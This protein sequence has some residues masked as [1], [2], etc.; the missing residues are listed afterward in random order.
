V[1]RFIIEA[2]DNDSPIQDV[3]LKSS[4]AAPTAPSANDACWISITNPVLS[5]TST[6]RPNGLRIAFDYRYGFAKSFTYRVH[7]WV[8]DAAGRSSVNA[9]T[10][11]LQDYVP[12]RY[13]PGTPPTVTNVFAMS[14]DTPAWP[15]VPTDLEATQNV[16]VFIKWKASFPNN[17][18][19]SVGRVSLF[20]TEDDLSYTLIKADLGNVA[21]GGCSLSLPDANGV[22]D[23]SDSFSGCFVWDSASAISPQAWANKP[24]GYYTV[25]VIA[26]DDRG[27]TTARGTVPPL[28]AL[29]GGTSGLQFLAGNTDPGIGGNALSTVFNTSAGENTC[30]SGLFATSSRGV[31]YFIDR[32][33]GLVRVDPNTGN[34]ELL[35]RVGATSTGDGGNANLATTVAPTRV[36]LDTSDRIYLVEFRRLRRIDVDAS[37]APTTIATILGGGTIRTAP[38]LTSGIA[39][40]SVQWDCLDCPITVLPSGDIITYINPGSTPQ[41]DF[42]ILRLHQ[43]PPAPLE[44]IPVTGAGF[45]AGAPPGVAVPNSLEACHMEPLGVEFDPNTSDLTGMFFRAGAYSGENTSTC[46]GVGYGIVEL[47]ANGAA[48]PAV[49]SYA[50]GSDATSPC[51]VQNGADGRLYWW[52]PD[53]VASLYRY[54]R[55]AAWTKLIG[56][57]SGSFDYS[58]CPDGTP[59]LNCRLNIKSFYVDALGVPYLSS[60]G[61]LR[62]RDD[63]GALV[64]IY[65]EKE[66]LGDSTGANPDTP[67]LSARIARLDQA[68]LW[69]DG[70]GDRL[71]L[72]DIGNMRLREAVVGG[73]ISTLAGTGEPESVAANPSVA[74]AQPVT[75]S[76][77]LPIGLDTRNGDVF[78]TYDRRKQGITRLTRSTGQWERVVGCGTANCGSAPVWSAPTGATG[79]TL[80]FIESPGV[81]GVTK[82]YFPSN[83]GVLRSSGRNMLAY[84]VG[85]RDTNFPAGLDVFRDYSLKLFD[86]DNNF[87]VTTIAQTQLGPSTTPPMPAGANRSVT[88]LGFTNWFYAGRAQSVFDPIGNR[89]LYPRAHAS[90]VRTIASLPLNLDTGGPSFGDAPVTDYVGTPALPD[91]S[92][93]AYREQGGTEYLY[94]CRIPAN[95]APPNASEYKLYVRNMTTNVQT[96]LPWPIAS[97]QCRGT[98]LLWDATRNSLIFPYQRNGLWGVAEYVNPP[99]Y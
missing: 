58:N 65:G 62:T 2:E 64:T 25:R 51:M 92:S 14:S 63:N 71:V 91:F 18:A 30:M 33:N 55:P 23:T 50:P 37:G 15:L 57:A 53:G 67:S 61:E 87:A 31:V 29:L 19:P 49:M 95:A 79:A 94:Y 9:A 56:Q 59:A 36:Y 12:L 6:A 11:V 96:Q 47:D 81:P 93:I 86:L 98:S 88:N 48:K 42:Y 45:V 38:S 40:T 90:Y 89:L 10:A 66:Y 60:E 24:N 70:G 74:Y 34:S 44:V 32:D 69:R 27:I 26:T 21:T 1:A 13:D 72:A 52:S 39:A 41:T 99:V 83:I 8:R 22:G 46:F 78:T 17:V 97:V 54:E 43:S 35:V 28:N 76:V 4:V 75:L 73:L 7:V 84:V 82:P 77:Q 85:Y 68:L 3:C 20:Y 80:R 16:P 5:L